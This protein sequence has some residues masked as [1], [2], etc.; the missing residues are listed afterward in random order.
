MRSI[1]I[2]SILLL[3]VL[4]GAA[5]GQGA[6]PAPSSGAA[7]AP[8]ILL[9]DWTR[10]RGRAESVERLERI[11][12]RE[13]QEA[14]ARAT[15][16]GWPVAARDPRSRPWAL[17]AW[18]DGRPVYR[19]PGA[20]NMAISSAVTPVRQ[21]APYALSGQGQR[22]GL[23][24]LSAAR[25]DHI[26]LDGRVTLMDATGS[27]SHATAVAGVIAAWEIGRAHV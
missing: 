5:A 17:V 23:W 27:G 24:D 1:A 22:A 16:R 6:L 10:P 3:P 14:H 8:M 15:A 25:A 18:R 13:R 7:P 20:A 21:R 26:E 2:A 9:E 11:G 4:A 19:S 12:L